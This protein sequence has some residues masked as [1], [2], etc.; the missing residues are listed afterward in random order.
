MAFTRQN[1]GSS[2]SFTRDGVLTQTLS[3]PPF[4]VF[5]I[6]KSK[7]S[8][9]LGGSWKINIDNN[10]NTLS[11]ANN[12]LNVLTLTNSGFELSSF[13]LPSQNS[14][15]TNPAEGTMINHSGELKIYL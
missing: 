5:E 8:Y 7:S 15:V 13:V 6:S 1:T 3:T 4:Q 14:L 2:V 10:A 11:F 9:S 12:S